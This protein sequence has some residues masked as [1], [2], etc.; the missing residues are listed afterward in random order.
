MET[1]VTNRLEPKCDKKTET[2]FSGCL[3]ALYSERKIQNNG[4]WMAQI[5]KC[6]HLAYLNSSLYILLQNTKVQTSLRVTPI[7]QDGYQYTLLPLN[8]MLNLL[9]LVG[10]VNNTHKLCSLWD[11]VVPGKFGIPK[12]KK[13]E[14]K[15]VYI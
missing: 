4:R 6:E 3:L 10:I 15:L 9:M 13:Y 2:H 14:V 11:C 5:E 12:V 7:D 1:H 8:G